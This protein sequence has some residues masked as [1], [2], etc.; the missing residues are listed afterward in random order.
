MLY[1]WWLALASFRREPPV[2]LREQSDFVNF[3]IVIPAHNEESTIARTLDSC[4][5]LDYP[6]DSIGIFVVADNCTD[7]TALVA[8]EYGAI[9]LE[10]HD[11]TNRGKGFA[12]E[13]GFKQVDFSRYE[14]VVVLDAD[15][16]IDQHA[17]RVF[18]HYLQMGEKVLQANDTGSNPDESPISYALAVGSIL[19]NELFYAPKSSLGLAVLLRGTGMVLHRDVLQQFPWTA[20]SITEDVEYALVL[21]RNGQRIRFI[22]Q[23][24]VRSAFPVDSGQLTVQ[25][26]RWASG[27]LGF[28][29][30]HA[31]MLIGEG[32]RQG[33]LTLCDAGATFLVLSRP[34]VI[35]MLVVA[36][37]LGSG[38]SLI[39]PTTISSS[40]VAV[41]AL[42]LVLLGL[43]F[44]LGIVRLGITPK[45]VL[46]LCHMPFVVG[47]LIFV[48]LLGLVGIKGDDWARTP[49]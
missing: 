18:N 34:L 46:C 10:R 33:N 5:D 6:K 47:R 20:Y 29:K 42:M 27:N 35:L 8:K 2:S 36:L 44:L 19:E 45:R 49:R 21:L 28:G 39:A 14:A 1:Y 31:L 3:A 11:T 37:C 23:A 38:V 40:L 17:L 41:A 43:Y 32:L 4:R 24:A 13:F 7:R 30:K 48:S 25:R 26:T 16:S 9:C 22:Q 15:C 12:L